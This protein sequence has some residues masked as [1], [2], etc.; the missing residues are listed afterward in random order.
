MKQNG[1][2]KKAQKVNVVK[3]NKRVETED[4]AL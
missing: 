2:N 1:V 4:T 3:N